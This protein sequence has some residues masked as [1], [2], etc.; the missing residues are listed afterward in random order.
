MGWLW[1]IGS[2]ACEVAGTTLLKL[3]SAG[4]K[5]AVWFSVGVAVCYGICFALLGVAMR[6]FTLGTVYATWSGLGVSLIAIIRVLAFGDHINVM[7]L[8]SLSLV[9]AGIVGLNMSGIS[10]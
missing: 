5:H 6:H 8:I 3:A 4:G 9:G 2:I 10:H 7:K 1:L